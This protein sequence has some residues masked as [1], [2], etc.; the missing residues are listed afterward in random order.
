LQSFIA[1]LQQ[2]DALQISFTTT[3]FLLDADIDIATL[4]SLENLTHCRS[5]WRHRRRFKRNL[6]Q[7]RAQLASEG[8][9]RVQ[10]DNA[11]PCAN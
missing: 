5:V 6:Q 10:L 2:L 1:L 11:F 9:A 4:Y 3:D 7:I 8:D